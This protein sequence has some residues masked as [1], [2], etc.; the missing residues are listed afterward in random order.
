MV[1]C[2]K[3]HGNETN[4][5]NV[6]TNLISAQYTEG[7]WQFDEIQ[8]ILEGVQQ[9]PEDL[10]SCKNSKNVITTVFVICYLHKNFY[11]RYGEWVLIEKKSTK[12]LKS[13]N[14]SFESLRKTVS[15]YC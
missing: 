10:V 4:K 13:Y 2:K 1:V 15:Q 5:I 7:F 6:Y 9:I 14:V 3:K 8:G 11:E 12:W